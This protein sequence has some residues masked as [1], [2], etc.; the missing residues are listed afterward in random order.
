MHYFPLAE[1]WHVYVGFILLIL[2][3]A[4]VD[5]VL[6]SKWPKANTFFGAS[7]MT[8]FW[9]F[10]ALLFGAAF[11][12]GAQDYFIQHPELISSSGLTAHEL[13]Q[14]L[15]TEYFTGYV[16]ELFLSV[17]NIFVFIVIFN[18]FGIEKNYQHRILFFGILGAL[19]CRGIFIGLGSLVMSIPFVMYALGFFLIYTGIKM[20]RTSEEADFDPSGNVFI[21]FLKKIVPLKEGYKGPLFF[22]Q[23][24]KQWFMTPLFVTLVLLEITDV[25]FAMDSV[26]AIFAITKE[27]FVVFSSNIFAILGLRSLFLVLSELVSKFHFLKFG[28]AVVLIFIG[29][30]MVFLNKL[31][32]GH[33]P[34]LYSLAIVVGIIGFSMLYSL[35]KKPA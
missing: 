26:P 14:R 27:P 10:F 1:F 33:F 28:L 24:N 31:W 7:M 11:Y 21:K 13:S 2:M 4:F 22:V 9:F 23:E 15:T 25:L 12:V 3:G 29:L 18:Y 20:F 19:I 8:L 35:V 34:A 30:K 32:D 17:D 5:L 6:L 16:I